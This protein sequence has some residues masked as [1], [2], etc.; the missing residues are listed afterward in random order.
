[1]IN[2]IVSLDFYNSHFFIKFDNLEYYWSNAEKFIANTAYPYASSVGLLSYEPNRNIYHLERQ[3]G[4]F[5]RGP[6]L[7]EIQWFEDNKAT[8]VPIIQG[9]IQAAIPIVTLEMRRAQLLGETDWLVQR[10]QEQ[11][12]L[13][14]PTTLSEEQYIALLTYKQQLRDLTKV[15]SKDTPMNSV[16]WPTNPIN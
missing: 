10:H 9:L 7:V 8:L 2:N 14:I 6:E 4:A 3:G 1:M 11:F 13:T 12:T 5:E 16:V 15:Y